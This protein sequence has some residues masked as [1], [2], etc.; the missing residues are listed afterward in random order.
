MN[1]RMFI[2]SSM[3]LFTEIAVYA[4]ILKIILDKS[5]KPFPTWVSPFIGVV[6]GSIAYK[7]AILI[8]T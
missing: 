8:C 4:L 1:G 3:I 5:D 2:V 7:L 6:M